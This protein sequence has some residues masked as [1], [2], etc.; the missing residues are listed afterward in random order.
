MLLDETLIEG[1]LEQQVI[2]PFR[3][4]LIQLNE[5]SV[6]Y[7]QQ[8]QALSGPWPVEKWFPDDL[9]QTSSYKSD[10]FKDLF[11]T[12]VA[13]C[14]FRGFAIFEPGTDS[15]VLIFQ[16]FMPPHPE[17]TTPDICALGYPTQAWLEST[18]QVVVDNITSVVAALENNSRVKLA[19]KLDAYH[20]HRPIKH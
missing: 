17:A 4:Q 19:R 9:V 18:L 12:V 16:P 20:G 15:G 1:R 3:Q 10:I 8:F 7:A 5:R 13:A 11:P 14:Y 6:Q 2:R